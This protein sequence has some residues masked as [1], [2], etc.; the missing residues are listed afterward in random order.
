[1][2]N[3][4]FPVF[5]IFAF[6]VFASVNFAQKPV[7]TPIK[8]TAAPSKKETAPPS[9]KAVSSTTKK[10][11]ATTAKKESATPKKDT[12]ISAKKEA[13]KKE[14]AKK[15]SPKKE[16]AKKES[17]KKETTTKKETAK[18]EIA[19]KEIA[20]KEIAKKEIAPPV[21][22]VDAAPT[23]KA[24]PT[25]EKVVSP[26]KAIAP[27]TE[28]AAADWKVLTDI[29]RSEKWTRADALA[30]DYLTKLPTENNERQLAQL[31]YFRLYALAGEI[32][33]FHEAKSIVEENAA[34]ATLDK[35]ISEFNGQ[36]LV[37][38]PHAFLADCREKVNFVCPVKDDDHALR[39]TATN[40]EGTAIHSFNYVSFDDKIVFDN[41]DGGKIFLGGKLRR[42]EFN[43]DLS[44][45][46][47]MRLFFDD[48]FITRAAVK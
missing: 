48:G 28:I 15:E 36:E 19:K 44:K 35:T 37:L 29:L 34:W 43:Q 5:S 23:K 12:V 14:P 45:P 6:A 2:K 3:F 46:W 1:M 17:A 20:K 42:A 22:K 38:P 26:V 31:R 40:K 11:T 39:V 25:A 33:A 7:A 30:A 8:K 41:F 24:A 16:T 18:K 13:L 4:A 21:K 32:A 10:P 27:L 47:L 9:K